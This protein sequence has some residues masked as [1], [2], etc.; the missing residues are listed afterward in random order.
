M[1]NEKEVN[2]KDRNFALAIKKVL[3]ESG[4]RESVEVDGVDSFTQKELSTITS[5]DLEN[6]GIRDLAGIE[7][8]DNLRE[9][10]ISSPDLDEIDENS[11]PEEKELYLMQRNMIEDYSLIEKL[12]LLEML[13]IQNEILLKEINLINLKRLKLLS[14]QKNDSLLDVKGLEELE[15]LESLIVLENPLESS[16]DL[17]L[18]LETDNLKELV[19]DAEMYPLLMEEKPEI[20]EKLIEREELGLLTSFQQK[21]IGMDSKEMSIADLQDIDERAE[22]VLEDIIDFNYTDIEKVAAIYTY[23]TKHEIK[24]RESQDL[25]DDVRR[26][27]I[28]NFFEEGIFEDHS[29]LMHYLLLKAGIRSKI[30]EASPG[31]ES[32]ALESMESHPVVRA[33]IGNDWYYFDPIKDREQKE[34]KNFYKTKEEFSETHTLRG[35]EFEIETPEVKGYTNFELSQIANKVAVDINTK[36]AKTLNLKDGKVA[37]YQGKTKSKEHSVKGK[38]S[39]EDL[40]VKVKEKVEESIKEETKET[41]QEEYSSIEVKE[42]TRTDEEEYVDKKKEDLKRNLEQAFSNQEITQDDL[43]AVYLIL[44]NSKSEREVE[45]AEQE[46]EEK[47]EENE[48]EK[49]DDELEND[50]SQGRIL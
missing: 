13:T 19:L 18:I 11:S 17:E 43:D 35:K 31:Y 34:F 39:D 4:S 3:V 21:V 38:T 2:I 30:V 20:V 41:K 45:Q 7:N 23:I 15:E 25:G 9:L 22:F 46:L 10:N 28:E 33:S 8:L 29:S 42:P 47:I 36:E 24:D 12:E 48:M 50:H 37:K 49:E 16:L 14:L 26:D 44:E 27:E 32:H 40:E 1:E 5:L 6:T